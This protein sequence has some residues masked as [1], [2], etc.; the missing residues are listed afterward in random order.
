MRVLP[1]TG[2]FVTTLSSCDTENGSSGRLFAEQ[3]ITGRFLAWAGEL[4]ES[5]GLF[6]HRLESLY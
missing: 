4:S 6:I 3:T 2:R 1:E 5:D